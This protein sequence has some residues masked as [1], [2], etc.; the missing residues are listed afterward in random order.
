MKTITNTSSFC[1]YVRQS[2][3]VIFGRF[4]GV[5]NNGWGSAS[6]TN[7]ILFIFFDL[8]TGS[9]ENA[10]QFDYFSSLESLQYTCTC[11]FR[12]KAGLCLIDANNLLNR[13]VIFVLI[14]L[15][16]VLW[17]TKKKDL[18]TCSLTSLLSVVSGIEWRSDFSCINFNFISSSYLKIK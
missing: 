9:L 15:K 4:A 7:I 13:A 5:D 14:Q 10:I 12:S 1:G 6:I 18:M 11:I 3:D 16:P 8:W 17:K 2:R